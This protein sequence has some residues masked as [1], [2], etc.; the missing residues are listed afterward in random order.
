MDTLYINIG[1]VKCCLF[2]RMSRRFLKV[3]QH[4]PVLYFAVE[5]ALQCAKSGYYGIGILAL[6]QILNALNKTTPT[7]RHVVAHEI[8]RHR[9]NSP[10]FECVLEALKKTAYEQSKRELA[11]SKDKAAYRRRLVEEWHVLICILH[12]ERVLPLIPA[13]NES[14]TKPKAD[15]TVAGDRVN[16]PPQR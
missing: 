15:Q 5:E 9:P 11:K 8:L 3:L 2:V 16:P 10:A 13:S 14:L 12:P 4:N 6:S 7:S 1:T